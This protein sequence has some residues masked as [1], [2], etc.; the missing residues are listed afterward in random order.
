VLYGEVDDVLAAAEYLAGQPHVDPNRIYLGGHS[1]GGTLVLLAAASSDRFRAVF[2]FGP[3]DDV[4]GYGDDERVYASNTKERRLRSPKYWLENIA[5]PTFVLEGNSQPSNSSAI[6]SLDRKTDNPKCHFLT[7]NGVNHFSILAPL[8][9]LL[10][11]KILRDIGPE[12]SITLTAS[13]ASAAVA[14]Q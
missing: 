7:V 1:T 2:S 9:R 4:S 5:T 13:E 11:Q 8:N 12:C 10:A 3:A 14:T 6:S